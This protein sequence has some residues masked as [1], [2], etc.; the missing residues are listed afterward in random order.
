MGYCTY[1]SHKGP[2]ELPVSEFSIRKDNGKPYSNCK[3]CSRQRRR[4]YLE[5][6]KTDPVKFENYKKKQA[7]YMKVWDRNNVEKRAAISKRY[8][9]ANLEQ[10]RAKEREAQRVARLKYPERVKERTAKRTAK[11]RND[12]VLYQK[13]LEDCRMYRRLR[14]E[15]EGGSLETFRTLPA[16]HTRDSYVLVEP[17]PFLKWLDNYM[18]E[19]GVTFVDIAKATKLDA[20]KLASIARGKYKTVSIST[21]DKLLTTY[22]GPPYQSFYPD[23]D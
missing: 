5:R 21:V 19:S 22:G 7:A 13:H 11:I 15:R 12:P 20:S 3:V 8:R 10:V 16:K 6:I 23:L 1:K 17:A 14:M 9:D 18:K 4:D 2:R